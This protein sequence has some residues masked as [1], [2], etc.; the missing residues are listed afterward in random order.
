M[1]E[2]GGLGR[3]L[4]QVEHTHARAEH[5]RRL[6]VSEAGKRRGLFVVGVDGAGGLK[7]RRF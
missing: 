5:Q 7:L 2:K 6:I 3:N 4:A 1:E